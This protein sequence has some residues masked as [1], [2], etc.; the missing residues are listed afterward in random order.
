[1][2]Y[3]RVWSSNCISM[4]SSDSSRFIISKVVVVRNIALTK[5][6]QDSHVVSDVLFRYK[7]L[8]TLDDGEGCGGGGLRCMGGGEARC[9]VVAGGVDGEV[10]L[11]TSR[12]MRDRRD[13]SMSITFGVGWNIHRKTFP[14]TA[15]GGGGAVVVAAGYKG[16][17]EKASCV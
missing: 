12:N 14:T 15:N 7:A 6:N 5:V 16:E 11:V 17:R 2:L 10:V 4:R 13:R 3:S 8:R 9:R 1:M